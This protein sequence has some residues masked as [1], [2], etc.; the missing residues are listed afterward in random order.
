MTANTLGELQK[1]TGPTAAQSERKTDE[2]GAR[3]KVDVDAIMAMIDSLEQEI[4]VGN[5][6]ISVFVQIYA[7]LS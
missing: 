5:S 2:G 7:L 1:R 3:A 6:S 4:Q